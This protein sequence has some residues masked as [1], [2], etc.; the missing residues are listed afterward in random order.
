M[1]PC[2]CEACREQRRQFRIGLKN[3]AI[4]SAICLAALAAFLWTLVQLS[5]GVA[6]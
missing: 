3:G 5:G 2:N 4:F 6:P 1:K